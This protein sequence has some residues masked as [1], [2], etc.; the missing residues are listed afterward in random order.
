[1]PVTLPQDAPADLLRPDAGPSRKPT[2]A[3][4]WSGLKSWPRRRWI[5]A[6]AVAVGTTLV[7]ALGTAMIPNPIIVRSVPTT[8]WAWPALI[9]T[10]VL[11]GLLFATYVRTGDAPE[12]DV[13]KMGLLGGF[14]TFIAVGC[15]VCNKI[16][17]LALG[18]TG[19]LQWFAPVQPFIGVFGIALL[20][21]A[22]DRRLAGDIY[23]PVK[24][25]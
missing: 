1:M 5:V 24:S 23:C 6:L 21:Y 19:A 10:A 17:L 7:I 4:A 12:E 9:V 22:L 15:P 14:L 3:E 8:T 25:A 16:A 11:S 13:N 2:R 18:Y 20:L